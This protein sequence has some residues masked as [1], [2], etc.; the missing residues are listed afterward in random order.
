MAGGD[1]RNFQQWLF[2]V[3]GPARPGC[4]WIWWA[5]ASKVIVPF[6]PVLTTAFICGF[7][8]QY[9]RR[10][11]PVGRGKTLGWVL[12]AWIA[13]AIPLMVLVR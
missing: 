2:F 10:R 5:G 9:I 1:R 13:Q 11:V 6:L 3:L 12:A 7:T 8:V 4:L